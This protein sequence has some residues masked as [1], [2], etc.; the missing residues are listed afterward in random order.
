MLFRSPNGYIATRPT[1]FA[2]GEWLRAIYP[3]EPALALH[4]PAGEPLC[5][6]ACCD[7]FRQAATFFPRYFPDHPAYRAVTCS[8]WLFYPGL[9]DVLPP[10]A[11]IV[12]FQRAFL[13]FPVTAA[14][15]HQAWERAF[16]PY[17][18]AIRPDQLRGRC[19]CCTCS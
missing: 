16:E 11:N 9:R 4:I 10:D 2:A 14:T 12:R 15:A 17:G 8:S 5:F 1:Q 19:P 7:A 18:A 3:R 6:E 13:C